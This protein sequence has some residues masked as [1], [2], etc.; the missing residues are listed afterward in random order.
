[1]P[2]DFLTR[3]LAS[4]DRARQPGRYTGADDVL[5]RLDPMLAK[6]RAGE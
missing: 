2:A 4:R 5:G 6:A 1:M 3:G